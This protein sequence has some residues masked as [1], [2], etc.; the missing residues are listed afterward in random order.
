MCEAQWRESV[1]CVRSTTGCAAAACLWS[2]GDC[3]HISCR[4]PL[5]VSQLLQQL[6]TCGVLETVRISAAG[7]PSRWFS[8]CSIGSCLRGFGDCPHISCR[9][10]LQVSQL[11]QQLFDCRVLETVCIS[12]ACHTSRWVSCCCS[13]LNAGFGDCPH[14]SCRLTHQVRGES[15]FAAAAWMPGFG[16]AYS[17]CRQSLQ[18]SH[19]LS[20]CVRVKYWR[21]SAYQLPGISPGEAAAEIILG[22]LYLMMFS[23][24]NWLILI[25][26]LGGRTT[27][28][29]PATAYS[30]TR[31]MWRKSTASPARILSTSTSR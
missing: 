22:K 11:L 9:L 14:I 28:S 13:C 27:T 25:S 21:P 20:S 6:L 10:S 24:H 15:A 23:P 18:V 1:L 4:L 5:Q 16:T 29:T 17:S 2:S 12:A 30:A 3:P 19:L 8:C 7:Y 26:R 31:K